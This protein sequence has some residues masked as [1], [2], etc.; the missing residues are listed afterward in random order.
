MIP[1]CWCLRGSDYSVLLVSK[2]RL[3]MYIFLILKLTGRDTGDI[4]CFL[5]KSTIHLHPDREMRGSVSGLV[6]SVKTSV[7][8]SRDVIN[9]YIPARYLCYCVC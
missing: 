5:K 7:P 3:R 1:L 6:Q 4:S 8:K 9:I 2:E